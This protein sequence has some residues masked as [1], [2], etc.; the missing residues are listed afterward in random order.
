MCSGHAGGGAW[1]QLCGVWSQVTYPSANTRAISFGAPLCALCFV[2]QLP[3]GCD[4]STTTGL[5]LLECLTLR[6][7]C[8][9]VIYGSMSASR[10]AGRNGYKA[11]LCPQ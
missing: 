10:L 5:H 8:A 1:A 11:L 6:R 2:C 4:A 7:A 3:S 9:R